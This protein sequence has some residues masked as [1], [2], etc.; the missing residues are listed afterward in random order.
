MD[1]FACSAHEGSA[2]P[3]PLLGKAL[4]RACLVRRFSPRT[5]STYLFWARRFTVYQGNR[6]PAELGA[7][8]VTAFLTHLATERRVAASTQNQALQALLFLFDKV[9]GQPLP[10]GAV[11]AVRARRSLRLPTVLTRDEVARFFARIAGVSRLV[12]LLQYGGGLRLM[13]ALRL[14]TKDLDLERRQVLVRHGKGGKDRM[15]PL[16][17]RAVE[18]LRTHLRA[19]WQQHRQDLALGHGAVPLPFS[20]ARK[21]PNAETNW[22]WQWVFAS[23]R[24][25]TDPNDGRLK[26]HHLD[27][28]TVQKAYRWAFRDAG[29][30]RPASSHTLRHSFATHLLTRGADLRAIQ[31]LLGHSSL[32]TTQRYT[33]LDVEHLLKV[34]R[35]AHPRAK[36]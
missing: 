16:P 31:E 24:V 10:P 6:H 15:V 27:D 20:L 3:L 5:A 22:A 26:R 17:A 4:V 13:E 11:Q 14:R 33:H 28:H 34:Y 30:L 29:I 1:P 7:R 35:D 19:R 32:A 2:I 36:L 9:L 25:S 12:A 18:P 23:S 8:E 21:H